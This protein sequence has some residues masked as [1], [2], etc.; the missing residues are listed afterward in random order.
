MILNVSLCFKWSHISLLSPFHQ[1]W[2][3]GTPWRHPCY[4]AFL[5]ACVFMSSLLS[6]VCSACV[7][8]AGNR[9]QICFEEGT[10]SVLYLLIMA[11]AR[12]LSGTE[13]L[14]HEARQ[15]PVVDLQGLK[16]LQ[17]DFPCGM[18]KERAEAHWVLKGDLAECH[19]TQGGSSGSVMVRQTFE[20]GSGDKRQ[21]KTVCLHHNIECLLSVKQQSNSLQSYGVKIIIILT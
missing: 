12:D 18:W 20:R 8:W 9:L 19:I 21:V 1:F 14:L 11:N 16:R 13:I 3:C 2:V 17:A 15:I 4:R 10:K 5:C 6:S 7:T